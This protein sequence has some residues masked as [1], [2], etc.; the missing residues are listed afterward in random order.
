MQ[1]GVILAGI[2]EHVAKPLAERNTAGLIVSAAVHAAEDLVGFFKEDLEHGLVSAGDGM[3][4]PGDHIGIEVPACP[5]QQECLAKVIQEGAAF[6]DGDTPGFSQVFHGDGIRAGGE[7]G[8]CRALHQGIEAVL[9]A[10][11]H[12]GQHGVPG[13]DCAQMRLYL[14]VEIHQPDPGGAEHGKL[15]TL[16]GGQVAQ[17]GAGMCFHQVL[18]FDA[19]LPPAR[20]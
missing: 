7:L 9:D 10:F 13:V 12:A 5:A 16:C 8:G 4:P 11:Q 18:L 14:V 2:S 15:L 20:G 6:D 19:H 17:G 3:H 1:P